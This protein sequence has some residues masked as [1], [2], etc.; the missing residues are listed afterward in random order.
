MTMVRHSK[1]SSSGERRFEY[2]IAAAGCSVP[3]PYFPYRQHPCGHAWTMVMLG[4]VKATLAMPRR[5]VVPSPRRKRGNNRLASSRTY[6]TV[7]L[8]IDQHRGIW[9][10]VKLCHTTASIT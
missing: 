2:I 7:C 8:I 1:R 10:V 4:R 6:L 5:R 9:P 3:R